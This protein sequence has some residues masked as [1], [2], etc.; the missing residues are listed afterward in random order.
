MYRSG[1]IPEEITRYLMNSILEGLDSLHNNGFAH[2][3]IKLENCLI[4]NDYS[5]KIADFGFMDT[6]LEAINIKKG[7]Q[8]Y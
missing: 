1:P 6:A 4:T 5:V 8:W 2:F 3:D 7:S